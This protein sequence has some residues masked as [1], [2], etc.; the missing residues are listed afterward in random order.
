MTALPNCITALW[1]ALG[2]FIVKLKNASFMFISVAKAFFDAQ[3]KKVGTS[4]YAG[5]KRIVSSTNMK[6]TVVDIVGSAGVYKL[7]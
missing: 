7:E 1:P 2:S 4:M 3:L 5:M 6:E